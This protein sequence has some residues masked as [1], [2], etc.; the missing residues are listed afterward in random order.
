MKIA[1]YTIT[2]NEE[3]F[4]E[5]WAESCKDADI[6]LVV[7]T[8]STD[9]T[10]QKALRQ[11]CT[12]AS[13]KITPW[14]FDD[15]RNAALALVPDDI[16]ICI[17]LDADEVLAPGWREHLESMDKNITRPRYK[18]VWSWNEDG[19]EGLVYHGDKIHARNGYR[20]V[21][22]V[23]EVLAPVKAEIQGF[24][25]LE[26]HH[27]PDHTKSRS[28]YLPLLELAVKEKPNDDRN[29]FYLGREYMFNGMNS[30]AEHCL[31]KHLEIS[32]WLPERATSM[33]YLS[34]VTENKEHWLLKA[35]A[36]A[37]D[38]REPWVDLAKFYYEK[39][40]W[41]HSYAAAKRAL[42][43]TVKPLEYLCEA[44]SW[45][46]MPYDLA[47]IASWNMGLREK[48]LEYGLKAIE[49]SP[50]DSRLKNNL[51]LCYRLAAE[52]KVSVI[53]PTKSNFEGL[54]KI[55]SNIHNSHI[56]EKIY[57]IADGDVCYDYLVG[58]VD[59][60]ENII[61]LKTNAGSGIH[62]MW[63]LALNQVELSHC[64]F[65]NDDVDISS[66]D[67]AVMSGIL[68]INK[69]FGL[70]CPNYD[71]RILKTAFQYVNQ[72]CRGRYD[73]SGGLA[74]FA[75]MLAKGLADSWRFD[76]TMKWWFG[77]DDILNWV[78]RT[79]KRKAAL[80][81]LAQCSENSSWTITNDPPKDFE[82]DIE[83]DRLIF[84]LKWGG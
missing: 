13:V 50:F 51:S 21:H 12:T 24:V 72:T 20:W 4:I 76:E 56:V 80:T 83:N 27:H 17:A 11:G 29:L 34:R 64:L 39:S 40:S 68:D 18:Y 37:P 14:R 54:F 23:H 47:F 73:G 5:R 55:I 1:V 19:S 53:I 41:E 58:K 75:M 43:I 44:E 31:L 6:R 15:A 84:A 32:S 42:D 63:N 57:I 25:G 2:K 59:S 28:Q 61:L 71:N 60:Y 9:R 52:T 81:N 69:D 38:R 74:G 36:E 33:R 77:D 62:V 22:P 49:S 30:E 65:L 16:D 70:V 10:L 46:A 82:K 26:I 67:I 35:C 8:G 79:K 45:G 66:D 3:K 48:S 7:D 78:T